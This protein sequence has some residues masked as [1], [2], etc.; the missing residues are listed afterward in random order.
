VGDQVLGTFSDVLRSHV[1]GAALI[2]RIGGE[3]FV[4]ILRQKHNSDVLALADM[5]RKA[6]AAIAFEA[7]AGDFSTTTSAGIAFCTPGDEDFQTV[8]RRADAALYRAKHM[9]RNKVC[10]ELHSVA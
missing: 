3:E 4:L 10:T 2:S 5:I 7:P 8:F 9:G 1:K 6:F